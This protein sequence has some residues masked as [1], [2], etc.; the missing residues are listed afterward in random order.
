M[1]A[2]PFTYDAAGVIGWDY[3]NGTA[4]A[5]L[6]ASIIQDTSGTTGQTGDY[7]G[8]GDGV[9]T[10][11]PPQNW[12]AT[13]VDSQSAYWIRAS[14]ETGKAANVT[15]VGLTNDQRNGHIRDHSRYVGYA[16]HRERHRVRLHQ[17]HYR[18]QLWRGCIRTG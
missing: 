4:W 2:T 17:Y 7:F 10:F 15:Q 16:P 12:A 13:T 11:V 5:D 9:L 8:E 6:D 18:G 14:V 1:S 3:W